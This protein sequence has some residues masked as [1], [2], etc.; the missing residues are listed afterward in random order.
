MPLAKFK[1]KT[2]LLKGGGI[3]KG[4][5]KVQGNKGG[6]DEGRNDGEKSRSTMGLTL[7]AVAEFDEPSGLTR[8]DRKFPRSFHPERTPGFRKVG[9]WNF[10]RKRILNLFN[11]LRHFRGSGGKILGAFGVGAT[12]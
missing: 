6:K 5:K 9:R 3:G 8:E 12:F 1:A 4:C 10:S 11:E 2:L 7:V